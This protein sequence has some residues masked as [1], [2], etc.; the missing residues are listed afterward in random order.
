[1]KRMAALL[2]CVSM[3]VL[4]DAG[5]ATADSTW[6]ASTNAA[7]GRNTSG[8]STGDSTL[9]FDLRDK[10]PDDGLCAQIAYSVDSN[11]WYHGGYNCSSSW[12]SYTL[13]VSPLNV[14]H[15]CW[16]EV[17]DGVTWSSAVSVTP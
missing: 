6:S 9:A 7:E 2:L 8:G 10:N 16:V 13:N 12:N 17:G 4:W 11:T 3:L 5:P 14:S 15:G 1:M